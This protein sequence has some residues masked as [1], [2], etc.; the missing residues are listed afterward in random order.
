VDLN[1]PGCP[2]RSDVTAEAI[3]ALLIGKTLEIP[4]TNL[5]EVCPREKLP[6]GMAMDEIKRQFELGKSEED[7]CLNN[8]GISMY[9]TCDNV[10]LWSRMPECR[11]SLQRLL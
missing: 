5:C 1:I 11:C 3:M 9:G 10:T 4:N 7:V 6:E 2:P 8:S